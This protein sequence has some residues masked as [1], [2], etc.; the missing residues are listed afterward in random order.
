[1]SFLFTLDKIV[2]VIII[3][4]VTECFG[5]FS[6]IGKCQKNAQLHSI[7]CGNQSASRTPTLCDKMLG[8]WGGLFSLR[9][10]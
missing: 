6:L 3:N 9:G 4:P 5:V 1:M 2:N 10:R 7:F 8:A